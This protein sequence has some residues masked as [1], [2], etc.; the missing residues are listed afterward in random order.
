MTEE[1]MDKLVEIARLDE[2]LWRKL[3]ELELN[4][5]NEDGT[6]QIPSL[7]MLVEEFVKRECGEDHN[8]AV[9]FLIMRLRRQARQELLAQIP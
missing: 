4:Q 1:Q 5:F 6:P 3:K 7:S 8:F 9:G 2:T